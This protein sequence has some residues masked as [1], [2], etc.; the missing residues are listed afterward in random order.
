MFYPMRVNMFLF[1]PNTRF[2]ALYFRAWTAIVNFGT[3][4]ALGTGSVHLAGTVIFFS[5]L[6]I[7]YWLHAFPRLVSN[8]Q[9]SRA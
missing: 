3:F 4:R 1:Q 2:P 9:F 8:S 6:G 7:G 5:A